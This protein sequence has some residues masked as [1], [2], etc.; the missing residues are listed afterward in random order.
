[1]SSSETERFDEEDRRTL[2]L[3]AVALAAAVSRAAEFEAKREQVERA[4]PLRGDVH[5]LR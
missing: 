2:E 4:R 5:R 3:L 1:M